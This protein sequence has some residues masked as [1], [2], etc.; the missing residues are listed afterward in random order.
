MFVNLEVKF[1]QFAHAY[2]FSQVLYSKWKAWP[3]FRNTYGTQNSC[4]NNSKKLLTYKRSANHKYTRFQ[5]LSLLS[6]LHTVTLH[7]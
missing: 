5:T 3:L 6:Y 1:S 2:V 7:V 4:I